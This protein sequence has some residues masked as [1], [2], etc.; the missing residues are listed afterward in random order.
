MAR[1]PVHF[2]MIVFQHMCSDEFPSKN[3][4]LWSVR[5]QSVLVSSTVILLYALVRTCHV[6]QCFS[7]DHVITDV[8][9]R[10]GS[11]DE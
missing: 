7:V 11:M 2:R 9:A 4:S 5:E 1:N 10:T 6:T 8:R 3:L